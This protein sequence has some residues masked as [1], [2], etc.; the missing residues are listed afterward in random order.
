MALTSGTRIG[1]YE[2]L[3]ALGVGGMGEVYRARDAKL[4][5]DVALKILPAAFTNDPDRLARFK[6]EA[7]VLASLNH[8][9]IAHIYGFEDGGASHALVLE[10][11]EGP[12]LAD[13]I[14]RGPLPL[15]EAIAI[16]KQIAD[17][18][19]MAHEQGIVH[20]DLKPANVKVREDGTVK[21][22]DFGL[23]KALAPDPAS[24]DA[25]NSPTM[26]ARQT[27][28]GMILGTAAYMS[29]EQAKG[30]P[31]DRR[32]DVWAF[33]VVFTEMLTGRQVFS[34]ET[35]PEVMASVMKEEPEWGRLPAS[36][37]ASIHR[38]LRRTLEKDPKKRL[39]SM[40][41]VRL[42]LNEAESAPAPSPSRTSTGS[43]SWLGFGAAAI[44]GAIVTA[45]AFLFVVPA[46]R[47]S[48]VQEPTRVSVLGPAGVTLQFDAAESAISPDGKTL[49][50][51]TIDPKGST[52]LWV[53]PLASLDARPLAGTETGHLPFWSPDSREIGFFSDTKLK[54]IALAGGTVDVLC[55]AK[56]GR[57]GSWGS[58]DLIVFAPV[59]AGPLQMVSSNGGDPKPVTTLDTSRGETAHRFPSFLP[60]GRH[61]LFATLPMH[62]LKFDLFVGA[63]DGSRSPIL[64]SAEGAAVY[65]D[66]GYLLFSRQDKLVAQRFDAA[67]RQLSGDAL[68]VSDAASSTGGLFSA[69][70]SVS[71]SRTGTLAYLGDR[72]ANTT[73][74][75]FDRAGKSIGALAAPD[76]RY[77]EIAFSPDGQRAAIA[78][79]QTQSLADIWIAD[80][81]GGTT[82]FTATPGLNIDV[83]WAPDGS[84]I[85][86][87]SDRAGPRDFFVKPASGATPEQSFYSSK[88]LFKDSRFWSPDGKYIVYEQLDPATNRDLYL[89]PAEGD[90]TPVPYLRTS[91]NEQGATISPD[92]KWLAYFSD[93][94][95]RFELYVDSFPAPRRRYRI[96]DQG[97]FVPVSG[98][99]VGWR[100]DGRELALLGADGRTVLVSDVTP[101]TDFRASPPRALLTLPKDTVAVGFTPD[102]QR[103]LA[104]VPVT[105]NNTSTLTLIFN[106]PGALGKK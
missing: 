8:P 2:I 36:L 29:P 78:R 15:S 77:Q 19:D 21:V 62:N 83:V 61:F 27:E 58:Q 45:A 95:G 16:A 51:T 18:L 10:L 28:M 60:D 57:G 44:A 52:M 13:R 99:S 59:N 14:A 93:E 94:S 53:R 43:R 11:V 79:N 84:R 80:I 24:S 7:Q 71:A 23:A 89:L 6:R 56:D 30:K 65:A 63:I 37:P 92:G 90:K 48:A 5:R 103:L 106:W 98:N 75:W 85:L 66:P 17:A 102:L 25:M 101:G 34:G 96:T 64:L 87:S 50:F 3:S 1:T 22:L 39:S 33:G 31:A 82:R 12:T 73:L 42:E 105:D 55:D 47:S 81:G 41:D 88:A 100:K 70:P 9:N 76:G 40:S 86:F 26:T 74:T 72:L 35:A 20:R 38:L 54:K 69:G 91:F 104:A 49:A 97:A 67:S 32:A 4:N 68:A 46:L